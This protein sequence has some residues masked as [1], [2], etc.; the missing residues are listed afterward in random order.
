MKKLKRFEFEMYMDGWMDNVGAPYGLRMA[1]IEAFKE[2]RSLED[3]FGTYE[4][5]Y[6]ED[7]AISY[8]LETYGDDYD[9]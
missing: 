1:L 4:V 5:D 6:D 7:H 3:W 9:L 8:M 2:H